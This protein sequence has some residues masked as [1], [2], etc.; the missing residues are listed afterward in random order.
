MSARSVVYTNCC[1]VK[2]G[3][4]FHVV[5][6]QEVYVV[7]HVQGAAI[8]NKVPF[9]APELIRHS[10]MNQDTSYVNLKKGGLCFEKTV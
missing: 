4:C 3:I 10:D 7:A 9:M 6:E 2:Q 1:E 8:R 5:D